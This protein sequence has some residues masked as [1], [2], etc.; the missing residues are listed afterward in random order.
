MRFSSGHVKPGAGV[1]CCGGRHRG[2]ITKSN[3][4]SRSSLQARAAD[5]D[6]PARP[7]VTKGEVRSR[8]EAGSRAQGAFPALVRDAHQ[9]SGSSLPEESRCPGLMYRESP[10]RSRHACTGTALR[11]AR[12]HG[13]RRRIRPAP[14]SPMRLLRRR[15]ERH[16]VRDLGRR[17][18]YGA[19][20]G[21]AVEVI[22]R[23]VVIIVRIEDIATNR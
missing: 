9:Y 18:A 6:R 2:P 11:Q 4:R 23:P 16:R 13:T 7:S 8:T 3:S 5:A 15:G 19:V 22:V 12:S 10:P 1:A 20:H 21:S 14:P 17:P